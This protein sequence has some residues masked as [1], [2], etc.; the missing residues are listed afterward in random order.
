MTGKLLDVPFRRSQAI[1]LGQRLQEFLEQEFHQTSA[2]VK[3][4][5]QTVDQLRNRALDVQ[6]HVSSLAD[7][8]DYY[9]NLCGLMTKFPLEVRIFF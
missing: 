2:K 3:K 9:G 6:P 7:L 8:F 5:C 4:D 1:P